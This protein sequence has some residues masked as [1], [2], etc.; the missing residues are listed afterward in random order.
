MLKGTTDAERIWN[1]LLEKGLSPAG[2]A[3][4][5]G[6]LYAESGLN[7]KNL[8]NTYERSLGFTDEAYTAAVDRGSY[9][10][11]VK[12][13]A[14][15]GLAQWT[16]WSRKERLLAF[17]KS[18]RRSIGDLE[19][20]LEFLY[21][22]LS[23]GYPAVL[24][25]LKA[26][27]SIRIASDYVLLD[28]ERPAN[29]S[30]AERSRRA[31]FGE[32]YHNKFARTNA[33]KGKT[34]ATKI[35]TGKQ[36]A[37]RALE[38]AKNYKTVY[39]MGCF[40]APMTAANK[41]RYIN[42]HPYNQTRDRVAVIR[43]VSEDTFGFD[44]VCFIKALFWGW[45]GDLSDAY[46]GA[47]YG[48][49]GVPDINAD[50]MI[51]RCKG[52]STD[53]SHIEVGEALWTDGHIGIY[54]GNGLAVECTPSWANKVQITACNQPKSGYPTRRWKKHGKLPYVE[55][56]PGSTAPIAQPNK[57]Q[58]PIKPQSGHKVGDIVNF[59]GSVHYT[60][61]DAPAGSP[62]VP[63]LAKITSIYP[64]G[65]HP[66]HLV[67]E[68]KGQST[69][70]GWVDAKHIGGNGGRKSIETVA[71]EVIDGLWGN[72]KDREQRLNSAG[73]NYN[74]VQVKVNELLR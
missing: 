19:M 25:V 35:K 63:G 47:A 43:S 3:G 27:N 29:Q 6:N 48:T 52:V 53:F 10:N 39:V 54:I 32:A 55:Y 68:A 57:P 56:A 30:E 33:K 42:H 15:Y 72:G 71:K 51:T 13:S 40:G 66:Y 65:K 41:Q 8:Q 58:A 31:G 17:A 34:M 45:N 61:A 5:M 21:K 74:A 28:F 67:A 2:I 26:T 23:E 64:Q 12:D 69:V 1:H 11:F 73:Y 7:P 16:Y 49:N 70:Y 44:C 14:G 37:E 60:N 9:K 36:L 59:T 22:E 62:C 50:A 18:M 38:V 4:L 46:G 24:K 20:Q